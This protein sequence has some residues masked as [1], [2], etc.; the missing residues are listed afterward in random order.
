[1]FLLYI[2]VHFILFQKKNKYNILYIYTICNIFSVMQRFP[3]DRF[4]PS[5]PQER[6]REK[7][8]VKKKKKRRKARGSYSLYILPCNLLVAYIVRHYGR[9]CSIVSSL[10]SFFFVSFIFYYYYFNLFYSTIFLFSF[11]FFL[12]FFSYSVWNQS[13]PTAIQSCPRFERHKTVGEGSDH[14]NSERSSFRLIQTHRHTLFYYYRNIIL[15]QKY[16]YSMYICLKKKGN[17]Y[18]KKAEGKSHCDRIPICSDA[19]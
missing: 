13:N 15:T 6:R 8:R 17:R 19:N 18:N 2:C 9:L 11:H 10:A 14:P 3:I 4:V 5:F 1:M 12:T 16:I 7:L